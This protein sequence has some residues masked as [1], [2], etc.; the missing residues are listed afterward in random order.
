MRA[1]CFVFVALVLPILAAAQGSVRVVPP[2]TSVRVHL[3]Q[4][5]PVTGRA[6]SSTDSSLTLRTAYGIE[7]FGNASIRR[8]DLRQGSAGKFALIAGLAGAGVGVAAAIVFKDFGC[9]SDV[10]DENSAIGDGILFGG[11]PAAIIG[12]FIGALTP[13]WQEERHGI[14]VLTSAETR[15]EP[16]SMAGNDCLRGPNGSL[17][18]GVTS[19]ASFALGGGVVVNCQP[20]RTIFVAAAHIGLPDRTSG[21]YDRYSTSLNRVSIG[22]EKFI[23]GE[24]RGSFSIDRYSE[25]GTRYVSGG[26]AQSFGERG[27]GAGVGLSA[28]R[29]VPGGIALRGAA[30]LHAR[31]NSNRGPETTLFFGIER[32]ARQQ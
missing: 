18:L 4:P 31:P 15:V 25:T 9:Q 27:I 12:A 22:T 6:V 5:N 28:A 16:G 11:G 2:G 1:T 23:A 7:T 29:R 13:R 17:S 20:G 32:S 3:G 21:I 19:Y 30:E 26:S 10:C 8:T 24:L 14:L